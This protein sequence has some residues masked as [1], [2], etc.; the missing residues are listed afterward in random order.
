MYVALAKRAQPDA[1]ETI[2]CKME[3]ATATAT[4]TAVIAETVQ[5]AIGPEKNH[6]VVVMA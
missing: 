3:T 2:I 6:T 4:A 5:M 1:A